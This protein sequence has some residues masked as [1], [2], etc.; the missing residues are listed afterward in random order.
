MPNQS[1]W[2]EIRFSSEQIDPD[3]LGP[4]GDLDPCQLFHR[5][6]VAVVVKHTGKVVHAARV[7]HELL[8][9]PIFPHLFVAAVTV[10]NDRVGLDDEFTVQVQH[11]PQHTVSAWV[12]RPKV[13]G[14]HILD[15]GF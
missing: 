10:A 13:Q 7:G 12:L 9:E 5:Q 3:V 8:V 15:N 14:V 11:N 4:L 2:L 6:H 1:R